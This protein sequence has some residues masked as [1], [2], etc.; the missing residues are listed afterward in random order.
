MVTQTTLFQVFFI[1]LSGK[2]QK[3]KSSKVPV[4]INIRLVSD[5]VEAM[6]YPHDPDALSLSEK[7]DALGKK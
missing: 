1:E 5:A 4:I 2:K 6:I 7:K 3:Q